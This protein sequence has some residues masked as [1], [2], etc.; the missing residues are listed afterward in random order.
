MGSFHLLGATRIK[1]KMKLAPWQEQLLPESLPSLLNYS[2]DVG[3][4]DKR[5]T[6]DICSSSLHLKP[7]HVSF[8]FFFSQDQQNKL[9]AQG[10]RQVESLSCQ[11]RNV[12]VS[13]PNLCILFSGVKDQFNLWFNIVTSFISRGGHILYVFEPGL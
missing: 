13:V 11:V 1:R 9:T 2:R 8:P 10:G 7:Y 12:S 3:A 6:C 5:M 4:L